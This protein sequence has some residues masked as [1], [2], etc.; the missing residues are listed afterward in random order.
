MGR[1]GPRSLESWAELGPSLERRLWGYVSRTNNPG[2]PTQAP[3]TRGSLGAL[4]WP[5]FSSCWLIH[6]QAQ[7]AFPRTRCSKPQ[8]HPLRAFTPE[9]ESR[10]QNL[11]VLGKHILNGWVEGTW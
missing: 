8:P 3:W 7:L 2:Q 10:T 1:L 9:E 11:D 6:S 5:R 4:T